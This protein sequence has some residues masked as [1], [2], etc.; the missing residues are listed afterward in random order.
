MGNPSHTER[1]AAVRAALAERCDDGSVPRHTLFYFYGGDFSGL[2]AAARTEGY[3]VKRTAAGDGVVLETTTAVDDATFE[4]LSK[5][6]EAWAD[7]FGCDY[8]G[9]ECQLVMQ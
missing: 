2:G 5:Q 7:Q 9:W 4:G 1:D 6:M 3:E 8:D